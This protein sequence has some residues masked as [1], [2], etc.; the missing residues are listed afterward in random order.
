MSLRMLS[1]YSALRWRSAIVPWLPEAF[2]RIL[3]KG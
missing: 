3:A 2:S 1:L